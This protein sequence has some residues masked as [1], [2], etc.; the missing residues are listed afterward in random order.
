MIWL[1]LGFALVALLYSSVGFGGGST[2]TAL[3][4]ISGVPVMLV[5]LSPSAATSSCPAWGRRNAG[6]LACIQ[7]LASCRSWP[8]LC[9][10]PSWA[11]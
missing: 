4:V 9:R 11:D 2:Y 7:T 3:L 10:Q 1:T 8:C 6:R 5:R